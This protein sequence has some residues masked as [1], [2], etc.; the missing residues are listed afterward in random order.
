[1]A[2]KPPTKNMA[3]MEIRYRMAMRLWSVVSSHDLDAEIGV[4][5]VLAFDRRCGNGGH[6]SIALSDS[7]WCGAGCGGT[8]GR[9]LTGSRCSGCDNDLMYATRDNNCSSLTIPWNVGMIGL[10]P[11]TTL[12][13][14][15]R[16]DSRM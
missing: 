15:V 7:L 14:G 11:A 4:Q 13:P 9:L 16:M 12:A 3:V 1:M 6:R 8:A 5:V 10:N 2:A